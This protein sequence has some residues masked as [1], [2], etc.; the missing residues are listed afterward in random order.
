MNEGD[1]TAVSQMGL[2]NAVGKVWLAEPDPLTRATHA[3]AGER[4]ADGTD[5]ET[6]E[7]M[8]LDKEFN[9][10]EDKMLH[11]AGGQ[12]AEENCNCRCGMVYEMIEGG[13]LDKSF[14]DKGGPGS[15]RYPYGSGNRPYQ[16]HETEYYESSGESAHG[17]GEPEDFQGE[18]VTGLLTPIT[19]EEALGMGA[20]TGMKILEESRKLTNDQ[21]LNDFVT[22]QIGMT[23]AN[24][25]KWDKLDLDVQQ[26]VHAAFIHSFMPYQE[27]FNSPM[28]LKFKDSGQGEYASHSFLGSVNLNPQYFNNP[29]DFRE[30]LIK[31]VKN[32]MHP[33]GCD[34]IKSIVDHELGHHFHTQSQ[35][36]YDK[37][38]K[39]SIQMRTE[40]GGLGFIAND[41]SSYAANPKK[42]REFLAESFAMRQNAPKEMITTTAKWASDYLISIPKGGK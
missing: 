30:S 12:I 32:G 7:P 31:G 21:I 11:P 41:I 42:P 4:Y 23:P 3:A 8:T 17:E 35:E 37:A 28:E 39:D 24:L 20:E 29:V 18:P 26:E 14:F 10:G 5:A 34:T 36:H 38:E 40:K 2:G 25:A 22:M 1:M 27:Y 6:G 13:D 19:K 16:H 15:G 9:V 33:I